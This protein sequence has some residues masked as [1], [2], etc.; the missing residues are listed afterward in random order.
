MLKLI[1]ASILCVCGLR[2]Q[3]QTELLELLQVRAQHPHHK[4][5]YLSKQRVIRLQ[6]VDGAVLASAHNES[7]VLHLRPFSDVHSNASV[8]FSKFNPL[9]N[10]QA[11]TLVPHE[12]G[13]DTLPVKKIVT[14][15]LVNQEV[16]YDDYQE[17]SF[18]FPVVE[19]GSRTVLKYE[20]TLTEPRFL[21]LYYFGAELPVESSVFKIIADTAIHLAF[22]QFHL[23]QLGQKLEA[24]TH[25]EKGVRV[26]QWS[27]REVPA[28]QNEPQS[29]ALGYRA[30]H[31]IPYITSVSSELANPPS[32]PNVAALHQWYASLLP[33]TIT[34]QTSP[35][36]RLTDSLTATAKTSQKKAERIFKWV[37]TYV[38]YIAFEDGY[39]GLIPRSPDTTLY[40]RYG[41][42]KDM[43]LLLVAM[44]NQSG[45]QAFPAWVGTRKLPYQYAQIP[46]PIADNH[47]VAALK[48]GRET[49]FLDA[50]DSR[51]P[52]GMPSAMIQG[53]EALIS[54]SAKQFELEQVPV[55]DAQVNLF[56][57]STEIQLAG[58]TAH[59]QTLLHLGGYAIGEWPALL[60]AQD[61][62]K[63][64]SRLFNRRDLSG[65]V[66][67]NDLK[68]GSF[69]IN[70]EIL[71]YSKSIGGEL[72]VNLQL[73]RRHN[74][75][76]FAPDRQSEV[77]FPYQFVD[78]S[79][80]VLRVP[81][82]W[83]VISIPPDLKMADEKF[84]FSIEYEQ[85]LGQIIMRRQLYLKTLRMSKEQ[86]NI[87][88]LMIESLSSSYRQSLLL[89]RIYPKL[90]N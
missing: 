16:F 53:K 20:E 24:T 79:V 12:G 60:T 28:H 27:A 4:A 88:N 25:E 33:R 54:L 13:Y 36:R 62:A 67:A 80:T 66:Q 21:G 76:L 10:L 23:D 74:Y 47:M 22:G 85:Q 37:Q 75:H 63:L 6:L 46:T 65:T 40:R 7:C 5:V 29:P 44:L 30:A 90:K 59:L 3:A 61:S 34:S 35:L 52:L 9:T 50:T 64:L 38:Q 42:C 17:K 58:D 14:K 32:L 72:Y 81:Q 1:F 19:S 82:G 43:S 55:V 41:D 2:L 78:R 31:L 15:N 89:R 11:C 77:V 69:E 49:I 71:D 86:Q 56:A 68:N 18:I 87:W 39:G 73:N 45:L 8:V 70:S 83:E 51:L 48:L 57:D 26:Y 84:G